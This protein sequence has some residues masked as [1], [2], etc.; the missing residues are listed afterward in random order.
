MPDRIETPQSTDVWGLRHT[1]SGVWSRELF[2]SRPDGRDEYGWEIVQFVP[3]GSEASSVVA[4][5]RERIAHHMAET[6]T[7]GLN[8][9]MLAAVKIDELEEMIQQLESKCGAT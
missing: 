5:L 2:T 6:K 9:I 1:A 7:M 4:L 3:A 8:G